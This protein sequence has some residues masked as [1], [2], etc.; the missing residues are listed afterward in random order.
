MFDMDVVLQVG[1]TAISNFLSSQS[2]KL[3]IDTY[4]PTAGVRIL[5]FETELQGSGPEKVGVEIWD[6]SGDHTFEGCWRAV[7][8]EADGVLLVYNPDAPSQD[9]QVFLPSH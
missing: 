5:E 8:N 1:K 6:I 2:E 4:N 7:M 3:A 9:Q